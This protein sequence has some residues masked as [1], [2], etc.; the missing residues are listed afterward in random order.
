MYSKFEISN[1]Q[2]LLTDYCRELL[3]DDDSEKAYVPNSK[4]KNWQVHKKL[5]FNQELIDIISEIPVLKS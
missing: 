2:S 1:E 4:N 5:R 3:T